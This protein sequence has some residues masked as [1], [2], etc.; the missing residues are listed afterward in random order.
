MVLATCYFN[1]I[2]QPIKWRTEMK[3]G[4]SA[5]RNDNRDVFGVLSLNDILTHILF[6]LFSN[7]LESLASLFLYTESLKFSCLP[8]MG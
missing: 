1:K 6:G 7:T 2:K 4:S 8:A 3:S 5:C